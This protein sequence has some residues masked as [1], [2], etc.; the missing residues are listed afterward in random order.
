MID[1]L[2]SLDGDVE[3][4]DSRLFVTFGNHEF[5]KRKMKDAAM[6][7]KRIEQSNFYWLASN[8]DFMNN[9]GGE[10]EK[11][12][13]ALQR[14]AVVEIGGIRVGVYSITTDKVMPEYAAIDSDYAKV[15]RRNISELRGLGA[16][17]VIALTH[18]NMSEDVALLKLLGDAGPDLVLGGHEHSRQHAC[19]KQRCVI[20]ADAE[21]RSAALVKISIS[22]SGEKTTRFRYSILDVST[23]ASDPVVQERTDTW[24][25]RYEREYC[26]KD[27]STDGCLLA[28]I[29][30]TEVELIAEELEIRRYETNLGTYVADLMISAFDNIE[31]TGGRHVQASL[32]NSGSLRLNQNIPAGTSLNNWYINGL[33][34][35]DIP[36]RVIEIDGKTL[37]AVLQ[38]SV[39]DWTGS[40]WWLQSAGIAYRHDTHA[41]E[42]SDLH[43]INRDGK[44]SP[45]GDADK[46][47]IS[48]SNYIVDP[49]GDQDGYTMINLNTEV[50]YAEKLFDLKTIFSKDVSSLW[51]RQQGIQPK[52]PGRV[53]SS[54]R[55]FL[56]CV[57]SPDLKGPASQ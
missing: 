11:F 17:F 24:I 40:G 53:C 7:R 12:R 25:K 39:E 48:V 46:I 2:N 15:S 8:I 41:G 6:L 33:F 28:V 51:K 13:K 20:K 55:A 31:F 16:E 34:L 3:Q 52:L 57:L 26:A 23:I 30:K 10:S 21:A 32:I 50:K 49:S 38:H 36:L 5:D 35:Y 14:N 9:E 4:F 22:P 1:M 43:L 47:L 19:V 27:K 56:P 45:I 44:I 29:G 37:K 54:D 42:I 18:L